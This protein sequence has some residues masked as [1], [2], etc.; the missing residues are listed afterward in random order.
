MSGA[1]LWNFM[2]GRGTH[3]K[4]YGELKR[5]FAFN[6]MPSMKYHANSAWQILSVLSFN[7]MRGFQVATDAAPRKTDGKRRTRHVFD[8]IHTARFTWLNRPGLVV[9]P[10]GRCTLDVGVIPAVR[11]KFE[12]LRQGLDEYRR[13]L[14]N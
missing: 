10:Q 11:S 6:C 5:G 12:A 7:L 13:F 8:A 2:C 1:S 4:A 9:G 3:E 14:S